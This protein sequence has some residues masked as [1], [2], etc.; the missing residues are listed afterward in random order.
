MFYIPQPSSYYIVANSRLSWS[1]PKASKLN[2]WIPNF[3]STATGCAKS[4]PWETLTPLEVISVAGLSEQLLPKYYFLLKLHQQMC[5][6]YVS[7]FLTLHMIVGDCTVHNLW[8]L[9]AP[10]KGL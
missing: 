10:K 2:A 6:K 8:F 3:A 7:C 4:V 5:T 9:G 1:L